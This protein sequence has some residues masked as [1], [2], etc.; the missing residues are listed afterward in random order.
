MCSHTAAMVSMNDLA[1][2]P[3]RPLADGESMIASIPLGRNE[4]ELSGAVH[5]VRDAY[6]EPGQHVI[7]TFRTGEREARLIRQHVFAWEIEERRRF[8]QL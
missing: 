6:D 3:P 4:L 8:D 7:L 2:R 5:T 1:D